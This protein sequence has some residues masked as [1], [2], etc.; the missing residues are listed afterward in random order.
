M[1]KHVL[2]R[3]A[4]IEKQMTALQETVHGLMNVMESQAIRPMLSQQVLSSMSAPVVHANV[5]SGQRHQQQRP[6]AGNQVYQ[7]V[8][9]S[10]DNS[11]SSPVQTANLDS[12]DAYL[13]STTGPA[14]SRPLFANQLTPLRQGSTASQSHVSFT[15]S[16]SL[17]SEP[18]PYHFQTPAVTPHSGSLA[19]TP[20]TTERLLS[21]NVNEARRTEGQLTQSTRNMPSEVL[22][23][24]HCSPQSHSSG[25]E[26]SDDSDDVLRNGEAGDPGKG[27]AFTIEMLRDLANAEAALNAVQAIIDKQEDMVGMAN[28]AVVASNGHPNMQADL[29]PQSKRLRVPVT[30]SA[31]MDQARVR[32]QEFQRMAHD[33]NVVN[34]AS[35]LFGFIASP[36]S[37]ESVTSTLDNV[38]SL[39]SNGPPSVFTLPFAPQQLQNRNC[40]LSMQ[41]SR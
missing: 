15:T 6:D 10:S 5:A 3:L 11:F 18:D 23:S 21:A 1:N 22:L 28:A 20:S 41:F 33:M 31:A 4:A 8:R 27:F 13:Y 26:G 17:P 2:D 32:V 38:S 30:G 14:D 36:P 29:S 12:T 37:S 25:Q 39:P 19:V 7:P 35:G 40:S 24:A 34:N 9:T 16:P